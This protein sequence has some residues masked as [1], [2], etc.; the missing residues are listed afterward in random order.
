MSE[1]ISNTIGFLAGLTGLGLA[2][3]TI[4]QILS[5][6]AICLSILSTIVGSII[7]PIVK[8]YKEAKK[9]GKIDSQDVKD[10]IDT[11]KD[12]VDK[13]KEDIDKL[14]KKK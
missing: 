12:G 14:D 4:Q 13:T 7:I 2:M 8:K 1:K 3:D 9:D 6:V 10:I 11:A 5:I